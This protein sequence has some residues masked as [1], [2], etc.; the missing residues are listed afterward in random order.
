MINID[1]INKIKN[2]QIIKAFLKADE[3]I[4]KHKKIAVSISGGAD[5]D[6][7]LDIIEKV[8][9][10]YND[11]IYLYANT[12]L[13]YRA[14]L[15]HLTQLESKYNIS[16][17]KIKPELPI[18]AAIKKYGSPII[19]K[20]V[21]KMISRLQERGF[22]WEC[23]A[24]E[25]LNARYPR[26]KEP[27]KWWSDNEHKRYV[28]GY[29]KYLKEFITE[30]KPGFKISNKCCDVSKKKALYE[31]IEN[32]GCDLQCVGLRKAEGGVRG[33]IKSCYIEGK[34]IKKFLPIFWLTDKDKEEYEKTFN[35]VHSRCYT[36]YGL[37]RT[38][39]VGC[40]YNLDWEEDMKAIEEY[41]PQLA[42]A[43]KNVFGKSYEYQKKYKD[44]CREKRKDKRNDTIS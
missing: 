21:S 13:E 42:K 9:N 15:E 28:I 36:E 29:N 7:M 8:K 16:I 32:S 27:I 34:A 39:C 44:F 25:E 24:E 38:G 31:T 41:E 26:A 3:I 17:Q 23:D 18:P 2:S 30:N 1:D 14:T 10:P 11:I 22:C 5:S 35:I 33:A 4:G 43:C 19:S 12:G 20:H 40:P 37:K 6:I